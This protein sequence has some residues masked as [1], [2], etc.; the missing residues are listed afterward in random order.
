MQIGKPLIF[1]YLRA[2]S[3]GSEPD[4]ALNGNRPDAIIFLG[5]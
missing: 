1:G 5:H 4:L 2:G 3:G